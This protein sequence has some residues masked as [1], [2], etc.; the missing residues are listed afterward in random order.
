[1]ATMSAITATMVMIVVDETKIF[2]MRV[3]VLH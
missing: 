2:P 1:M 3:I